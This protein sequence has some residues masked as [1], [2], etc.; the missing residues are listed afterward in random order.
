MS[1]RGGPDSDRRSHPQRELATGGNSLVQRDLTRWNEDACRE[2]DAFETATLNGVSPNAASVGEQ[3]KGTPDLQKRERA[4][5]AGQSS[6]CPLTRLPAADPT[7]CDP[8]ARLFLFIFRQSLR[9]LGTTTSSSSTSQA[10]LLSSVADVV[11]L[12]PRRRG[13]C[14]SLSRSRQTAPE[15]VLLAQGHLRN[16]SG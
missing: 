11:D 7:V 8:C 10:H 14:Q 16:S 5:R 9:N 2:D 15:T 6:S 1:G 12:A 4:K 13:H 3:S